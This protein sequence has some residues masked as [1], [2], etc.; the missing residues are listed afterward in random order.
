MALRS[1]PKD[2]SAAIAEALSLERVHKFP[3]SV[4][5]QATLSARVH[6]RAVLERS[7]L[8]AINA[9]KKRADD[10]AAALDRIASGGV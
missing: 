4:Q 8:A 7:I 6:A 10:L 3:N 5:E 9:E 2:I 1:L